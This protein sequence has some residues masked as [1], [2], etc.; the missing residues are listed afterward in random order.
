MRDKSVFCLCPCSHP[1]TLPPFHT[2]TP[3]QLLLDLN[4]SSLGI[5]SPTFPCPTPPAPLL[6][7]PP[8]IPTHTLQ[9]TTGSS[10]RSNFITPAVIGSL[11]AGLSQVERAGRAHRGVSP[12]AARFQELPVVSSGPS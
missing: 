5:F 6:L 1:N 11:P 3:Q 10:F 2:Q 8:P 4:T 12:A 7:C 9:P